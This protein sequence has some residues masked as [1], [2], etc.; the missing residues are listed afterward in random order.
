MSSYA[1]RLA[2]A[3]AAKRSRVCAGLDPRVQSLP[4]PLA[5]RAA[6]GPEQAAAAYVEFCGAVVE[7]VADFAPVV[8]PQAA[9]FEALGPPGY[10]A[11]WD[12]MACA[13]GHGLLVI[14]DAKRG[15]VGS[16][17]AAYAQAYFEPPGGLTGP[18]ALTVN[19]YL[20]GD[21]VQPFVEAAA[22]TGRGIYV[23]AKTSNPSSG[24]LQDLP[25]DA[26]GGRRLVYQQMARLI[27]E[28]GRPL[29]GECGYSSVGAVVGATYPAQLAELRAGFPTVPFL[30]PGYGAQG[31]AAQDVAPAFDHTG[32]GAV[33]NS[34]RGIIFA[35]KE[36]PYRDQYA[37]CEFAQ[38]AA[39][40]ARDMRDDINRAL[41]V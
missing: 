31:G 39:A 19:G 3:I 13:R 1:D 23:L 14:L 2:A 36:A 40:A 12:V 32:Q 37:E 15:D 24:D 7:A 25:T 27:A 33:V 6:R 41:G 34:S 5:A 26:P 10:K 18:D 22:R 8:K 4:G 29:V 30:V 16:T 9:F 20:G 11:L 17:A 38:A 28:W 35:Y 21:G